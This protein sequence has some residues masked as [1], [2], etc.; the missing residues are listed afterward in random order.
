MLKKLKSIEKSV[1]RQKSYK[2]SLISKLNHQKI[3]SCSRLKY[4]I[5]L[6]RGNINK[7]DRKRC[8]YKLFFF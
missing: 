8:L 2:I 4:L 6:L 7:L 5:F 1:S 3:Q